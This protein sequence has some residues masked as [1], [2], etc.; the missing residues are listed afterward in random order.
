MT[1]PP[2]VA[3]AAYATGCGRGYVYIRGEYP[4]ARHALEH[5]LAEARRRGFLGDDVMGEGLGF[6]FEVE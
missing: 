5:A 4:E 2:C 6:A 1:V 3:V